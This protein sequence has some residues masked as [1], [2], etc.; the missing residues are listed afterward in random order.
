MNLLNIALALVFGFT[1]SVATA[2]TAATDLN[3]PSV[4][5]V[6]LSTNQVV[7]QGVAPAQAAGEVQSGGTSGVDEV[8]L[9]DRT[10]ETSGA[11]VAAG[12]ATVQATTVT[13][14]TV[15]P[16]AVATTKKVVKTTKSVQKKAIAV[17][18]Q[19]SGV[20]DIVPAEG[21][22]LRVV[23][24]ARPGYIS[25]VTSTGAVV[26]VPANQQSYEVVRTFEKDTKSD[27]KVTG[28]S[29]L[30]SEGRAMVLIPV[31]NEGY[32]SGVTASG[33]IVRIPTAA[34][35]ATTVAAVREP[36]VYGTAPATTTTVVTKTQTVAVAPAATQSGSETLIEREVVVSEAATAP[37]VQ[38]PASSTMKVTK[39][40]ASDKKAYALVVVG[41]GG[42]P[43]VN[44][45]DVGY[46][47]TGALG[48]YYNAFMFE[49]GAGV[50]KHKMNLRNYSFFNRVDNFDVDQYK[51]YVAAKY[52]FEKGTLGLSDKLQPI[53]GALLSY[54]K[55]DYNLKNPAVVTASGNTGSSNALDLGLNAGLDYEF[56]SKFSL[57][58]DFKYMFNLSNE[59]SATYNDPNFGYTGT[60]I[61][62]LQYYTAG[63]SAKVNF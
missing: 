9:F 36:V 14:T 54:T 42:Y 12:E 49:L 16:A 13:E 18:P 60:A 63:I 37:E 4:E 57:G 59:V 2:S 27:L 20:T 30:N 33:E 38:L 25:G 19:G 23:P 44:N 39:N 55:R 52:Q 29:F 31:A 10:P 15:V 35:K 53:A 5:C 22:N 32:I 3:Q 47:L 58:F 43:E 46:D 17:R 8:V 34:P 26:M 41:A 40:A 48:Y 24:V 62:K 11:A 21:S 51:G 7:K 56:T 6:D 61:E 28:R 1:T 45:V 50:A